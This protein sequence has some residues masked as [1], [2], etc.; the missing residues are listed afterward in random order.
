MID[1]VTYCCPKDAHK[2]HAPGALEALVRSHGCAFSRVL[3]VQQ[4]CRGLD[5][6]PF[7]QPCVVLETEEYPGIRG[8]FGIPDSDPLGDEMA[9][10]GTKYCWQN[11]CQCQ[12]VG[13]KE[14]RTEH[15]AFC[16]CD[17]VIEGAWR[18][19]W[20]EEGVRILKAR[21]EVLMVSPGHGQPGYDCDVVSQIAFV[22]ERD[23]MRGID[24]DLPGKA[25]AF[26]FVFE[27]RVQR[28]V[29]ARGLKRHLL[30]PQWG[31]IHH[32]EW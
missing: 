24:L 29:R 14:A 26:D 15:V 6:P 17:V 25:G 13:L 5:L 23:R 8:E 30:G 10:R 27:G 20:V 2:L 12:L 11:H 16:D 19:S 28:Y 32:Y 21:P 9:P 22:C 1:L 3:V 18:G 31:V 7:T 4:D